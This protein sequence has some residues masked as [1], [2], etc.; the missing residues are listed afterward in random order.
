MSLL[1]IVP[2][3]GRPERFAEFLEAF[4]A[5]RYLDGTELLV[6]LD[7]D[8]PTVVD[9]P[10]WLPTWA[11][12]EIGPRNG[13]APRMNDEAM[14]HVDHYDAI[15]SFGDDHLC[16]TTGWDLK[17]H[18][19]L[20]S[21]GLEGV[22]YGNDLFQGVKCPTAPVLST[23]IIKAL[24]WFSPPQLNHYW[25]D[26]FWMELGDALQRLR[27]L[28]DVVIEHMHPAAGKASADATY[29][30]QSVHVAHD[31]SA[32]ADYLCDGFAADVERVRA[33]LA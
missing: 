33:A 22:V 6:C 1:V 16:R 19:A 26:D 2:S 32:W 11:H 4:T 24:G 10:P 12:Y 15:A 29:D 21:M 28:G 5:T 18:R 20:Y 13:F 8:D 9:Y 30:E 27:Y 25:V 31:R 23:G 7:E 3:R 14:E 17:F